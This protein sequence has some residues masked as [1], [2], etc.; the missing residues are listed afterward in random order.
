[1]DHFAF[2][3]QVRAM[4]NRLLAVDVLFSEMNKVLSTMEDVHGLDTSRLD[5]EFKLPP[6]PDNLQICNTG[7][8]IL[9]Q[10][11]FNHYD[12]F[13]YAATEYLLIHPRDYTGALEYCTDPFAKIT[14]KNVEYC[15]M[16]VGMQIAKV[17]SAVVRECEPI[18]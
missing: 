4:E 8:E 2:S 18:G 11:R 3:G 6:Q 7:S 16:G 5:Q 14:I 17:S 12:C 9:G 10:E 1:M 13:I 15:I